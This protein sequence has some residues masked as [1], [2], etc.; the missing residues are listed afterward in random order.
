MPPQQ[1]DFR[2]LMEQLRQGSQDAA[3]ELIEQY[4]PLVKRVVRRNLDHGLRSKFDSVDFVQAVWG[5]FF[6]NRT[7]LD[8]FAAPENLSPFF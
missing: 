6:R 7:R 5:S 1:R 2:S 3:W 4:G 8:K